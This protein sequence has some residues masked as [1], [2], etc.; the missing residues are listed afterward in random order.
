MGIDQGTPCR[1]GTAVCFRVAQAAKGNMA[2]CG[3]VVGAALL[4]KL[5]WK[6][7]LFSKCIKSRAQHKKGSGDMAGDKGQLNEQVLFQIPSSIRRLYWD[8]GRELL[9]RASKGEGGG[10]ALVSRMVFQTV[11]KSRAQALGLEE[12]QP[13]EVRRAL[14]TE[15][16][17]T[18]LHVFVMRALWRTL[19]VACRLHPFTLLTSAECPLCG[20]VQGHRHV[21]Y[22]STDNAGTETPPHHQVGECQW[23]AGWR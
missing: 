17:P 21:L 18:S 2:S 23:K 11:R 16:I 5:L 14:S 10:L 7:V 1:S 9:D 15:N 13:P 6:S 8:A 4:H 22:R 3:H 20:L 19:P 12:R